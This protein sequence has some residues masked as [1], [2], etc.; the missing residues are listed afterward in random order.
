M[1][2]LK[3]NEIIPNEKQRILSSSYPVKEATEVIL[4]QSGKRIDH[5]IKK[6]HFSGKYLFVIG[7][8]IINTDLESGSF[9]ELRRFEEW[10]IT[11]K[12]KIRDIFF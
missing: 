1:S 11:T 6:T 5:L 7:A 2:R 9:V 4:E 8:V 3:N 12:E 10:D